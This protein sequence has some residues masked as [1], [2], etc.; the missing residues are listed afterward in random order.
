MPLQPH[1]PLRTC[2]HLLHLIFSLRHQSLLGT[3]ALCRLCRSVLLDHD[4]LV[5]QEFVVVA[6]VPGRIHRG[7]LLRSQTHYHYLAIPIIPCSG[8]D[9]EH[10]SV[11]T[12]AQSATTDLSAPRSSKSALNV[13]S[14]FV[15]NVQARTRRVHAPIALST[16]IVPHAVARRRLEPSVAMKLR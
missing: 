13:L 1:P 15:I 11:S 3:R 16:T 9:V 7:Y 8:K 6:A 2:L 14:L 10:T 4:L 5:Y 12:L